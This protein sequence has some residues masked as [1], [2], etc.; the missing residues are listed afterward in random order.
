MNGNVAGLSDLIKKPAPPSGS[1]TAPIKTSDEKTADDKL[2]EK[3]HEI[4]L[5][6][7]EGEA[8]AMAAKYKLRYMDLRK[9]PIPPE[10]LQL[11]PEDMSRKYN[12][13]PFFSEGQDVRIGVVNIAD[14]E[15]QKFLGSVAQEKKVKLV[16]YVITD[17]SYQK[18]AQLYAS[19]PK[20]VAITRD[21]TITQ[22]DLDKFAALFDS[23]PELAA[24][25][26]E[27]NTTDFISLIFAA[28]FKMNASDIHVEAEESKIIVRLRLDGMLH[29][30]GSVPHEMWK[31]IIGRIKLLA[32]LKINIEDKPQDGRITLILSMGKIDVRVSTIPTAYGES[33]VMRILKPQAN[34]GMAELGIRGTAFEK[35][36]HEIDRPNGMI[37]T[38]GPTGSG[39]TTTL[40][41]ILKKKN[42]PGVKII[43]LEDP[44][45]YKLE[46]VNQSQIDASKGYTF[47]DALKSILRQDPDICMVGEIRDL[48]TAEVAIQAALTGHLLLSTIHT[49]SAAGAIP[50]FLSMGVK[51]FLLAPALNAIIGQRL[52]RKL[53]EKCKVETPLKPEEVERVTK[54]MGELSP[55]SGMTFNMDSAKF[56]TAPGCKECKMLGY[57]GRV[58]IY[59]ICAMTP[60]IEKLILGAQMSEFDIQ[61]QA[62]A[63]GMVTMAQDGILKAAEGLS[64]LS[65][66]FRVAE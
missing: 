65:E 43:T 63:D 58:G 34:V 8:Q 24:K 19:L 7:K 33:V 25:M 9:F 42:Q 27:V 51:P 60:E 16:P 45:E 17:E 29:E 11:I 12:V 36:M 49:N 23:L 20:I 13:L 5:G 32:A 50:R 53:C 31:K 40:Y 37:I 64:S 61:K 28:A 59:E 1:S 6:K 66:V 2:G 3:I 44:V 30:I 47:A 56:F 41:T 46:G 18:G 54:I 14:P 52:M 21:V 55:K 15:V 26:K 57:K 4:D 48:P 22:E 10:A 35:L 62:V 39:K 38:T